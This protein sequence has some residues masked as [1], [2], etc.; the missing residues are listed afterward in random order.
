LAGLH[1]GPRLVVIGNRLESIRSGIVLLKDH[2]L[3]ARRKVDQFLEFS[4]FG[5]LERSQLGVALREGRS[6][7]GDGPRRGSQSR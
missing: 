5:A 7:R 1:E 4:M 6:Q 3:I 2:A